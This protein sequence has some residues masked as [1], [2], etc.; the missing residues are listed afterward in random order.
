MDAFSS[1]RSRFGMSSAVGSKRAT[2]DRNSD[3]FCTPGIRPYLD[4][5]WGPS[6]VGRACRCPWT[7]RV[8]GACVF[9]RDGRATACEI[10]APQRV[11]LGFQVCG[12]AWRAVGGWVSRMD[13]EGARLVQNPSLHS[14]SRLSPSL[15]QP[16]PRSRPP[17][18]PVHLSSA[19]SLPPV[20][21]PPPTRRRRPTGPALM[22]IN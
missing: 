3:F 13:E 20:L 9:L 15:L 17:L 8:P 4:D 2:V 6:L 18:L 10:C 5:L 11:F 14:Q 12:R 1:V 7:R 19:S 16:P 22:V 21:Y